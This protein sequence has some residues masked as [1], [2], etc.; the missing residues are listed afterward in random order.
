MAEAGLRVNETSHLDLDDIKWDL[1]RFGKL[2]VRQGKGARGSRPRERMVPLINGAGATLGHAWIATTMNYIH[3]H[4]T[5][6]ED[7]WITGQERAAG[8]VTRL[9]P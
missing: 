8:R 1:G 4:A 5:H 2:H 3:V 6:I 7:A 9:L